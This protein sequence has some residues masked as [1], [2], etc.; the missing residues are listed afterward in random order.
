MDAVQFQ[1]SRPSWHNPP[2]TF[3]QNHNPFRDN[4]LLKL[5][6]LEA[7]LAAAVPRSHLQ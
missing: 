5:A 4:F 3:P 2:K 1:S 6:E 7:V